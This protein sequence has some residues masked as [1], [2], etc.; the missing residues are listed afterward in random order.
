MQNEMDSW[1]MQGLAVELTY[2]CSLQG[3]YRET[4]MVMTQYSN[5]GNDSNADRAHAADDVHINAA[6]AP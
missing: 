4:V 1:L 6:T 5:S 2:P 3:K